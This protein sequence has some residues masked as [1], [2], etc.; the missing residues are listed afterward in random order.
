ME[1]EE[2][3]ASFFAG[4]QKYDHGEDRIELW[5]YLTWAWEF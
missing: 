3:S 2:N 5:S 4:G 1:W